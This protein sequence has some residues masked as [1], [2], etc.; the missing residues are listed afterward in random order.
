MTRELTMSG[1]PLTEI[2]RQRPS[3]RYG[4]KQ[5]L[6]RAGDTYS[7]L[8]LIKFGAVKT[9]YFNASGEVHITGFYLPGEYIGVDELPGECHR[10]YAQVT[11]DCAVHHLPSTQLNEFM[12]TCDERRCIYR[13]MSE[14]LR[15]NKVRF[16]Q[17]TRLSAG[18]KLAGFIYDLAV[19]YGFQGIVMRDFRLPMLRCDIAN[20]IGVTPET[21]TR[22]IIKL[23]DAGAFLFSGRQI[24]GLR[25]IIMEQRA[26]GMLLCRNNEPLSKTIREARYG[27]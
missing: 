23:V 11:D 16:R 8:W 26:G 9:Y 18:E 14:L 2:I 12:A 15:L 24:T 7:G 27:Q 13:M 25:P 1:R 22:E 5:Y 6:W 19:R 10:G 3:R 17:L 4:K 21:V 20:Y